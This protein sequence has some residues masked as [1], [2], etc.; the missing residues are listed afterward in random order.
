MDEEA[1]TTG[2]KKK[3]VMLRQY[4]VQGSPPGAQRPRTAAA[5]L[6]TCPKTAAEEFRRRFPG[7]Q[8]WL[9]VQAAESD[10]TKDDLASRDLWAE[11]RSY[12]MFDRPDDSP[13][14]DPFARRGA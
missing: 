14:E 4:V 9:V 7:R 5:I 6:G 10:L 3:T 1:K 13:P 2:K 11:G 12:V 8:V